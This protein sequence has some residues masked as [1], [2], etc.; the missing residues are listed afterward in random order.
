MPVA[1][2]RGLDCY[3]TMLSLAIISLKLADL[4]KN[5]F[6]CKFSF[7]RVYLEVR[8]SLK[9]IE[10]ESRQRMERWERDVCAFVLCPR[11]GRGLS[12]LLPGF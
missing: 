2:G 1:A 6:M 7:D 3:A 8:K 10:R 4:L 11:G 9:H 5:N 12:F